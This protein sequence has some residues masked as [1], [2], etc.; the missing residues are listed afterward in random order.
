ME[1]MQPALKNGRNVWDRVNM[2]E[3]EFEARVERI[4]A[5]MKKKGINILLLYGRGL[6]DYADPCYVSNF[7]IRLPRGTIALVPLEGPV[8]LFFEGASRGLPSLLVTTCVKELKAAGNVAS[9]CAKYLKEQGLIPCTVGIGRMAEQMP[10]REFR[11]LKEALAGCTIVD[12]SSMVPNLRT[13]KSVRECDEIRRAGRIIKKCF[14][15]LGLICS[16]GMSEQLLEAMIRKI[17]RLEGAEDIR[18]QVAVANEQR[19]LRPP[20]GRVLDS[21]NVITLY[22]AAA[23]ERYWAEGIKTFAVGESSLSELASEA[24]ALLTSTLE[25]VRPG[26]TV[27]EVQSLIAERAARSGFEV[28]ADYA[29]GNGV[30]LSLNELPVVSAKGA[31]KLKEGMCLAIRVPVRDKTL[32]KVMFG[33]TVIVGKDGVEVVT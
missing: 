30:G 6:T 13:I 16:M 31:Q 20:E 23:Y 3:S 4:R 11:A 12:A 19:N 5:Q 10:Y 2:P 8:V 22:I 14:D 17:A 29:L 32:G 1:T 33:S 7:I 18:I 26:M 24:P 27:A 15:Q 21:G 28:L 25:A 9:D